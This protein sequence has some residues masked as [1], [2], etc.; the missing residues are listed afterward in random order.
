MGL[1]L[2]EFASVAVPCS[3]RSQSD[4]F[5]RHAVAWK[6][7]SVYLVTTSTSMA[8]GSDIH[9]CKNCTCSS[10]IS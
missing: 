4:S 7:R 10:G 6:A 3:K 9:N 8:T 5:K 2:R 1:A